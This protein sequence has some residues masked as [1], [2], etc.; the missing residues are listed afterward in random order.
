M[1]RWYHIT[2]MSATV[3]H[4]KCFFFWFLFY[5]VLSLF[6]LSCSFNFSTSS[7]WYYLKIF[8]PFVYPFFIHTLK[9]EIDYFPF[10]SSFFMLY[11]YLLVCLLSFDYFALKIATQGNRIQLTQLIVTLK[12]KRK[13]KKTECKVCV[14]GGKIE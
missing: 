6:R 3:S 14:H 7:F 2:S 9:A 4:G 5:F 11:T 12:N 13:E 8:C 1:M 10:G